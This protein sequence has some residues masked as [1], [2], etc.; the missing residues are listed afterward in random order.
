MP[1]QRLQTNNH[2]LWLSYMQII[3]SAGASER[4]F[5]AVYRLKQGTKESLVPGF[6]ESWAILS[7][8]FIFKLQFKRVRN[9]KVEL[10]DKNRLFS[11]CSLFPDILLAVYLQ[12]RQQNRNQP[13]TVQCNASEWIFLEMALHYIT[14][15]VQKKKKLHWGGKSGI[16]TIMPFSLNQ[17]NINVHAAVILLSTFMSSEHN[18]FVNI[19]YDKN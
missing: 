8:W 12:S 10:S 5:Q 3:V 17:I 7:A 18:S 6:A 19:S 9:L 16:Y 11:G 2:F 1:V 4:A 13:S 14:F 15:R